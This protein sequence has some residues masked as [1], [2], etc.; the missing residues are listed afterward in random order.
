MLALSFRTNSLT[1][2]NTD[3][4]SSADIFCASSTRSLP[5]ATL[6][7]FEP[8][9]ADLHR[10]NNNNKINQAWT[11]DPHTFRLVDAA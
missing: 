8:V 1:F 3:V 7:L 9:Y 11:F 4:S 5:P 10:N 2:T 6:S